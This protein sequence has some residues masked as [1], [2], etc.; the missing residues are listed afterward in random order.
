MLGIQILLLVLGDVH[1]GTVDEGV[2]LDRGAVGAHGHHEHAGELRP[3]GA[4]VLAAHTLNEGHGIIG[5]LDDGGA[6]VVGGHGGQA[7]IVGVG[8]DG[9]HVAVA[10]VQAQHLIVRIGQGDLAVH[11]A[12]DGLPAAQH[13]QL[14][15]LAHLQVLIALAVDVQI[16]VAQ[17]VHVLVE[18]VHGIAAERVVHVQV[19]PG[20]SQLLAA[21]EFAEGP[22]GDAVGILGPQELLT[23]AL[24]QAEGGGHG[25]ALG[26]LGNGLQEGIAIVA[27]EGAHPQGRAGGGGDGDVQGLGN[28]QREALG[29]AA[30]GLLVGHGGG[31]RQI[32]RRLVADGGQGDLQAAALHKQA[33]GVGAAIGGGDAGLGLEVRA[34]GAGNGD[35]DGVILALHPAAAVVG[36]IDG[37]GP[38]Q[39]KHVLL[40]GL[41]GKHQGAVEL[42]L[43]VVALHQIVAHRQLG[44]VHQT[45]AV[46][47]DIHIGQQ[48]LFALHTIGIGIH[49]DVGQ[50]CI[51]QALEGDVH[52]ALGRVALLGHGGGGDGG[53]PLGGRRLVAAADGQDGAV[54]DGHGLHPA[55]VGAVG[56]EI[57]LVVLVGG[58][59]HHP[60]AGDA[61]GQ[62]QGVGGLV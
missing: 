26:L 17:V 16:D 9:H 57:H 38:D 58:G 8:G 18:A 54:M 4:E 47:L 30:H 43:G 50:L 39:G 49:L 52:V 42:T 37:V 6:R 35:V 1:G 2:G 23:A 45:V 36:G 44:V 5:H 60:D 11:E 61:L 10:A 56:G 22:V 19:V 29:A 27:A 15:A 33:G 21:G 48:V 24:R 34:I 51:V 40:I 41:H 59:G 28:G 7:G 62:G 12:L 31:D 20:H 25:V 53:G 46:G 55:V 32:A 14:A 3:D 13:V